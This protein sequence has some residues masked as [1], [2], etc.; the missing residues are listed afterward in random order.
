MDKKHLIKFRVVESYGDG[1]GCTLLKLTP[2]EGML[3]DAA[4]GAF[5]NVLVD[6][7]RGAFLR[8]PISICNIERNAGLLWLLVKRAG[9]GTEA[10]CDAS[11]GDIFDILI[12]LGH[13]FSMPEDK[14]ASP[15][16]VGGGV[17]VAPLLYWGRVLKEAGHTPRFLLGARSEADLSLLSE[18]RKIGHT[19]VCTEDG[20]LG[21][22]GFVTASHLLSEG[23]EPIYCCG[24]TP[25]MKA[26]AAVARNAGRMCEVSLEN[27]M[28]C[29]V[30]ACLCCVEKTKEGHKC[31]CTDG[32]VFNINDLEFV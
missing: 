2:V 8:R 7:C 16:L 15:L 27:H 11:P 32:P 26:I 25:M 29:G 19:E 12:P 14:D 10:I 17:G 23:N 1:R 20:S 4:P 5:V 3:P 24:P 18:F 21:T 6:D 13:G 22:K 30:G 31:V 9:G 28:A